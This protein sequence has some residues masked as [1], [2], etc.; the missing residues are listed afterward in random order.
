MFILISLIIS[1]I[2]INFYYYLDFIEIF[3]TAFKIQPEW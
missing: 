2:L 1:Y 3:N